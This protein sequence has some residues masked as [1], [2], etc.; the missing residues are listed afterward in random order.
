[1]QC[2]I[3]IEIRSKMSNVYQSYL[4]QKERRKIHMEISSKKFV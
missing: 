4:L 1:M 3:R 2:K